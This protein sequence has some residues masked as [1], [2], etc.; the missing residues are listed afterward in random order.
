[1]ERESIEQAASPPDG[2]SN[3]EISAT[4]QPTPGPRN[5]RARPP[6][7]G[8]PAASKPVPDWCNAGITLRV[9][10]GVNAILLT[11]AGLESSAWARFFERGVELAATAEP[12]LLA[13]L[14]IGCALRRLAAGWPARAQ[15][16]LAL[17]V[18]AALTFGW[19][20]IV[21]STFGFTPSQIVRHAIAAALLSAGVLYWARLRTL[22]FSPAL[23]QARLQALQARIRPHFLFN[24]LNAVL[25]MIRSDPRRAETAIED[26]ADLFRIL[27]RDSRERVPL[28]EE[29]ALCKQY[30]AIESLR[31]GDRLRADWQVDESVMNALVPSLLL[32]PLLEN[33]V[34]HGI[35]PAPAGGTI[36]IR[37]ARAGGYASIVISNPSSDVEMMPGGMHSGIGLDNVRQRLALIHDLEARLETSHRDGR[38]EV[39]MQFPIETGS[40]SADPSRQARGSRDGR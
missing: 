8:F 38:F 7:H 12:I 24:S 22:A 25:G 32:Q 27:M 4:A 10:V 29:V 2:V 26:L 13:S 40:A 37:I 6:A 16:A 23:A 11:L 3:R 39:K 17:L 35:E 15:A 18:P 19:Q 36:A 33:A 34:L 5:E 14:L 1:M 20:H 31:L 9:V 21:A 30:L 28:R